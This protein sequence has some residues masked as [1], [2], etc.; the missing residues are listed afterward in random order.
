MVPIRKLVIRCQ[1]MRF[2]LIVL[3]ISASA[4][5]PLYPISFNFGERTELERPVLTAT[6][7]N[8]G[9]RTV[10]VTDVIRTCVCANL[11]LSTTN[12]PPAV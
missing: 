7:R 9:E 2:P 3:S 6:L 4:V 10:H 12:L 8:D 11:E 1:I 5:S